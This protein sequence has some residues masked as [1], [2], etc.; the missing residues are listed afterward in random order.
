MEEAYKHYKP[1]GVA[2]TEEDFVDDF[3]SAPGV[4]F[5]SNNPD[6]DEDFVA[7]ISQQRFWN[8]KV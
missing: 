8:R 5:A 1:I 2:T 7:A 4:V 3:A 6:F